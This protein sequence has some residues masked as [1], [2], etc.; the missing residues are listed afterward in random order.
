M[1]AA[2]TPE[3]HRLREQ[4]HWSNVRTA[5]GVRLIVPDE[6]EAN[7]L[8]PC[9]EG[10]GDHYSENRMFFHTI[11]DE[12]WRGKYVLDYACGSGNWAIYFALT[13][14][15]R[16][17]G[18]DFNVT[19]I[20]VGKK[21]V[22]QQGLGD[23]VQLVA[24]DASNLPFPDAEF[25]V[26]IGNGALHHT[27]KYDAVF[28][29]L[30]RVMK[31]GSRAFFLENLADFPLWRLWWWLKGSVQEGDVPIF[32]REVQEKARMFSQVDIIGDTFVHSL[33]HLLYRGRDD[34]L[35]AWR[36]RLLRLTYSADQMLFR[37]FPRLR[38]WG[39]MSVI[40]LT[41]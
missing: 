37:V 16:V 12:V 13:G 22:Q 33:K 32:S 23:R 17:V 24:A 31:P 11:L 38:L 4:A 18:F 28:D 10:S 25:E 5:Q 27:I 34:G 1:R 8:R 15:K 39:S 7:E 29:N 26:V 20:E 35:N 21:A 19:G 6:I 2:P 30:R 41:K 14:A 36:K 3:E 40:V 9:F